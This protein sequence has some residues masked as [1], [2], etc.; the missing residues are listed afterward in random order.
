[1]N[2][3]FTRQPTSDERLLAG[4]A[5]DAARRLVQSYANEVSDAREW[6][7]GDNVENTRTH[8]LA[9]IAHLEQR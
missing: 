8:L 3:T 5:S 4:E 1:M 7:N 6:P 9:Y 2:A